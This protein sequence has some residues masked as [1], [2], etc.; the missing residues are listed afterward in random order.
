MHDIETSTKEQFA[1]KIAEISNNNQLDI[2]E[3]IISF[4]EDNLLDVDDVIPLLDKSM[5]D[6]I[7]VV[8][9]DKRY[10][11]GVKK[12]GVLEQDDEE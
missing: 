5:R 8:A 2:I 7:K 1:L 10:V 12:V 11:L 6:K 4:C 3:S 9:I